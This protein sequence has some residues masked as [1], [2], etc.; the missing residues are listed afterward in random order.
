MSADIKKVEK[1]ETKVKEKIEI[2]EERRNSD[3]E[4]Y[5]L[6]NNIKYKL[7]ISNGDGNCL[8]RSVSYAL[9][10]NEERH[11][12]IRSEIVDHITE[13]WAQMNEIINGYRVSAEVK[14]N[15]KPKE[16][17]NNAGEYA[18]QMK[19]DG[20]YGTDIE[21]SQIPDIYKRRVN[22]YQLKNDETASKKNEIEGRQLNL[23]WTINSSS[24]NL[25]AKE[26]INLLFS[27]SR[28]N[29]HFDN[30]KIIPKQK[31]YEMKIVEN[32][33]VKNIEVENK[34][35][36]KEKVEKKTAEKKKVKNKSAVKKEVKNDLV[37][38]KLAENNKCRKNKKV[39]ENNSQT[40]KIEMINIKNEIINTDHVNKF[41]T[42]LKQDESEN[43]LVPVEDLNHLKEEKLS[44][45]LTVNCHPICNK[46]KFI[47]IENDENNTDEMKKI[48]MNNNEKKCIEGENETIISE[49]DKCIEGEN[50]TIIS[51]NENDKNETVELKSYK[52][53]INDIKIDENKE[54]RNVD[55]IFLNERNDTNFGS[56]EMVLNNNEHKKDA[57]KNEYEP[58][59]CND[60][61]EIENSKLQSELTH[62]EN[63]KNTN[64]ADN[65]EEVL[66]DIYEFE[67]EKETEKIESF[68]EYLRDTNTTSTE[69]K[70]IEENFSI[71]NKMS[72]QCTNDKLYFNNV[73]Q[74]SKN[75]IRC[76]KEVSELSSDVSYSAID[77]KVT[78]IGE[79]NVK[80]ECNTKKET[81]NVQNIENE[82]KKKIYSKTVRQYKKNI[83]VKN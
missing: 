39:N 12:E 55:I 28:N 72:R 20:E 16:P 25:V 67:S 53:E 1:V 2:E 74:L 62:D 8:F 66:N 29:G 13:N 59:N 21:I 80:I 56:V 57:I 60:L 6:E 9:Y 52:D 17:Y 58:T 61:N 7:R 15:E 83:I 48:K 73:V 71:N 82:I 11:V 63:A 64:K 36:T 23:M 18:E 50:E 76:K 41:K 81:S 79:G 4:M 69:K 32:K 5:K 65:N 77:S 10:D 47:N 70:F 51:K 30:L 33:K 44:K 38:N 75:V 26:D 45:E 22:L 43:T 42:I 54:A 19:T 68:H 37:D 46:R 40:L 3:A 35:S 78:V 34:S 49:N 31:I 14:S 24:E 27:N